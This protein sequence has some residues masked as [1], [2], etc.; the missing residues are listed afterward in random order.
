MASLSSRHQSSAPEPGRVVLAP[1]AQS[2]PGLLSW[3]LESRSTQSGCWEAPGLSGTTQNALLSLC[4][5]AVICVSPDSLGD[6]SYDSR[7]P[8]GR[9]EKTRVLCWIVTS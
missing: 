5:E 2:G 9:M 3:L 6:S 7:S 4:P 8:G 1:Q